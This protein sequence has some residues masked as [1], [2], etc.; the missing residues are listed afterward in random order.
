MGRSTG[1]Q[2][3]TLQ[4]PLDR[5]ECTFV[6][7]LSIAKC[8]PIVLLV[9]KRRGIKLLSRSHRWL[10]VKST[11]TWESGLGKNEG[12][13]IVLCARVVASRGATGD[14]PLGPWGGGEGVN[15]V[16]CPLQL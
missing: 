13:T 10:I 15:S 3:S 2:V 16:V 14:R 4:P 1:S 12:E 11:D 9:D 6:C 8:F 7:Y 5:V